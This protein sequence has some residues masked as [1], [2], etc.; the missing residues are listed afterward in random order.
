MKQILFLIL[1]VISFNISS[2]QTESI[3]EETENIRLTD[4]KKK[5][6]LLKVRLQLSPL[7][8][9]IKILKHFHLELDTTAPLSYKYLQ[10]VIKSL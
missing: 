7:I 5:L 10:K 1:C 4:A 8:I 3:Q 9:L 6:K 2:A